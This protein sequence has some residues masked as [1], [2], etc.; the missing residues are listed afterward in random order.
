LPAQNILAV[1]PGS[2]SLYLTEQA[3]FQGPLP[4]QFGFREPLRIPAP[5]LENAN[6]IAFLRQ[7][8]IELPPRLAARVR[9]LKTVVRLACKLKE[10]ARGE[11]LII[12]ASAHREGKEVATCHTDGWQDKAGQRNG[13][14]GAC[15]DGFVYV[16]DKSTLGHFPRLLQNLGAKWDRYTRHW[17]LKVS[18]KFPELFLA[19]LQ[20]LPAEVEVQ[21]DPVLATL[22]ESPLLGSVNL[23]VQEAGV[24]WFDLK[25][26]LNVT[27]TELTPEELKLLLNARGGYVRLGK[28]GWKRLEYNLT[29]D[30]DKTLANLGL[31]A[32]DFTAEPQRLHALQLADQSA[33]KFLPEAQAEQIHRRASELKARVTPALP[34]GIRAELRPYQLEGFHFLAYL[35]VNRFGGV[36]ADDMGLGKTLQTLTWLAWLRS[37]GADVPQPAD[38][39]SSAGGSLVLLPSLVV[40]PK[41][42]M[43]NWRA[44]A[45]KFCAGM[46]V[47]LWQGEDA[48]V[49]EPARADADLIVVNY[50]QLRA[51]SPQIAQHR[52]R[53]VILDEAQ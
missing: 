1:L 34:H 48:S 10:A 28:K 17:A 49:L 3:V 50:S 15:A 18:K 39:K 2:P 30:E 9:P 41:S 12:S 31:N 47:R 14:N 43:D 44:E 22:R 29:D 11:E 19:W 37:G 24:D 33:H 53:A 8:E 26:A 42:V 35:T 38:G 4:H 40:C 13:H 7:H 25:V 46:R 32:R 5:A 45:E 20:A 51:L 52:W 21:L 16:E 6:G 27:D 36:L 23:D